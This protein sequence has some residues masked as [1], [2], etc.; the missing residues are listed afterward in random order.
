MASNEIQKLYDLPEISFIDDI[1]FD[2]ILEEM[3]SDYESFYEEKT[4]QKITLRPGDKEYIHIR[5][6]AAQYYQMY[7]KLDNSA[8]MN[9]LKYSKGDFLKHLGAFKKTFI[10]QPKAAIVTARFT[11]SGVRKDVIYIPAGTRITAGDAIYFETD[12][13][14]EISAGAEYVDIPCTC[15]TVGTVGNDYIV[16][17]ISTIVDPVPYVAAVS[18]ITKSE[19]GT[20]EESEESFRERIFLAPSSYSTAGPADAY[21]YWV[22]QYNSAAIE[23]VRIHEPEEAIVDIRILLK[24]GEIPSQTFCDGA[25]AYLKENPIIPLTDNDQ[26]APPDIVNYKLK[27]TYYIAR[28]NINNIASIQ[29]SIE[30]AKETY[31]NWQK[32]KIGRDINPDA[33]TEFV[34]A[35]GGKRVAIESPVFTRI[36]ETSIAIESEVEFVYGGVEDD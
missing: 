12:E 35:A 32:T 20:G 9:L 15:Q 10:D 33:L 23:D 26:V 22:K 4:G 25:L 14:A 18:N 5:I 28:S 3:I 13:Y 34:R 27:A 1:T 31:L 6:E 7:L 17:Q 16:G 29:E 30:G 2:E 21:E 24:G 19:G 11:L 8:K 36:P